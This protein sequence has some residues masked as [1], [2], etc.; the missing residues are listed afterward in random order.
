MEDATTRNKREREFSPYGAVK[1]E[2]ITSKLTRTTDFSPFPPDSNQGQNVA[3]P[4]KLLLKGMLLC[5]KLLKHNTLDFG[6][7]SFVN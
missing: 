6:T 3:F 5:M 1:V 4:T 2:Q 7:I